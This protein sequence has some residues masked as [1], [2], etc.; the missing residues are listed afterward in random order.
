MTT[1]APF[2]A[3][4]IVH[5][6]PPQVGFCIVVPDF[7][8]PAECARFIQQ[9][10]ARGFAGAGSDY[11]P[12]YRN[13]DRQV[14]DDPALAERLANR[15]RAVA[16]PSLA[17]ERGDTWRLDAINERFRF[18][19]YRPGQQ[20]ELHQDGVHHRG[21]GLR[22][23]LTFMIYLT[24]GTAFDGGDTVFF[25]AGPGGPPQ[26]IGRVRPQAGML[27]LFD[28][29]L[30]HAGE[31]VTAGIKHIM[32]SDVLYRRDAGLAGEIADEAFTPRHQGYVW[33]LAA[34]AG[35]LVASGGRD[36]SIRI[37]QEDGRLL[38]QLHGHA[39]SVLGMAALDDDRLASVSRDR[40]LRIWDWRVG[41]CLACVQ[42]HDSAV[43]D[44]QALPD[45]RLA[46][47]SADATIKLWQADVHPAGTL[48]GHTGWV[49]ELAPLAGGLLASASEDGTVRIWDTLAQRCVL[50]LPAG[51]ALRTL[52]VAGSGT[53]LL[54]GS[55]DGDIECW[56]QENGTWMHVGRHCAHGAAVRRL[57]R[58]GEAMLIST[59][60]DD[61]ARVW[62]LADMALLHEARHGN[63]VTDALPTP[64]GYLSCAYDGAIH[65]HACPLAPQETQ[66]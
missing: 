33:T 16:P 60:E 61:R 24:D 58:F 32:R 27:I 15:L 53:L 30:W 65:R 11:P 50:T 17:D 7:L 35:G 42:A 8:T 57:R 56:R 45:G 4:P 46:T 23:R 19:R 66:A 25:D 62:R 49:W 59:G 51:A 20:F 1:T 52:C 40:T 36:A 54:A 43:L 41:R 5:P 12:S 22:S 39:R 18:C 38:R 14:V 3:H 37:W 55:I 34:L 21:P 13:N 28:H 64:Y 29:A 6:L 9:S 26:I 2:Q 10:E 31:R 47:A 63:F 44:V 48:A